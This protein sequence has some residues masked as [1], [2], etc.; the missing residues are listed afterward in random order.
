MERIKL[1][2]LNLF[3]LLLTLSD[4]EYKNKP[5]YDLAVGES[6]EIYYNNNSCCNYCNNA[7]ELKTCSLVD[8]EVVVYGSKY[9][10]GGTSTYSLTFT[11]KTLGTDT[12]KLLQV[13]GDDSCTSL[14]NN[15]E[16]YIVHVRSK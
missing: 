2:M 7:N 3:A 13:G 4:C 12:I 9:L 15:A 10:K 1:T 8:E 16:K 6:F 14:M 11:A 5:V